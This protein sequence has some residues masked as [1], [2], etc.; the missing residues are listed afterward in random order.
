MRTESKKG[1]AAATAMLLGSLL[2]GV[3]IA[4]A[5]NAGAATN[6]EITAAEAWAF[7]LNPPSDS[8]ASKGYQIGFGLLSQHSV[9]GAR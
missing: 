9:V 5:Q 6:A 1:I 4:H 8:H 3:A 7:P 2:F